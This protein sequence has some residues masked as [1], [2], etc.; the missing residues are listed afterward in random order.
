MN[1]SA[2]RFVTWMWF[3][4]LESRQKPIYELAADKARLC[5]TNN[6]WRLQNGQQRGH[7]LLSRELVARPGGN[8]RRVF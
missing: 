4:G 6:P 1:S 8:L 2:P 7:V 3:L 5:L